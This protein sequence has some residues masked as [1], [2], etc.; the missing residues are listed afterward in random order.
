VILVHGGGQMSLPHCLVILVH[1]WGQMWLQHCL[2]IL[3]HC[4]GQIRLQQLL[5]FN[6]FNY[7]NS[8]IIL[9]LF[10]QVRTLKMHAFT[11]IQIFLVVLL[12]IVK[13]TLLAIAFPLFVIMMV[14]LRLKILPKFFTHQELEVVSIM[15]QKQIFFRIFKKGKHEFYYV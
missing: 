9:L 4:W 2:L 8:S 6:Y 11:V 12:W 5:Y 3:V 7:T 13:S 10:F 15:P 14:P 1:G